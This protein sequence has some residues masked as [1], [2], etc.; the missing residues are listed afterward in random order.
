MLNNRIV[1]SYQGNNEICVWNIDAAK[2]MSKSMSQNAPLG[3][4]PELVYWGVQSVPP[5]SQNKI[6]KSHITGLVACSARDEQGT[7]G[8]ICASSDMKMRFIDLDNP[9]TDSYLISSAFN[10]QQTP[11]LSSDLT[12]TPSS[13]TS[14]SSLLQPT[15]VNSICGQN[16]TFE[17]RQIEGT[18][19]LLETDNTTQRSTSSDF[20]GSTT[21]STAHSAYNSSAFT[22]QSY[23][24]HHQDA[25]TDLNVCY[26][27]S[28]N[29]NQPIIVTAARDGTLKIW[30]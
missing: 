29:K 25:I 5:L 2:N 14:T 1:A 12:Q 8:L 9:S 15:S 22:H 4:N 7:N 16:T 3:S 18:Q 13:G 10:F 27:Q 6:S 24:T 28:T 23:F 11:K 20:S 21:M 19:V 26:N 17:L 30:R